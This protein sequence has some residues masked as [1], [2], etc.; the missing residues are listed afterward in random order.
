MNP[1][2]HCEI[3]RVAASSNS[4]LGKALNYLTK[5]WSELTLFLRKSGAPIDNNLCERVLKRAILHRKGSLFYKT[6]RGAQV[7]DIYMSLI[8]TCRLADDARQAW[9]VRRSGFAKAGYEDPRVEAWCSVVFTP[10]IKRGEAL[11]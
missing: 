8:H 9:H 4:P 5:H 1:A 11:R 6:V 2:H 10:I 3:L 7:G